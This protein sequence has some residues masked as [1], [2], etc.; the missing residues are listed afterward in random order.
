MEAIDT[1]GMPDIAGMERAWRK[2]DAERAAKMNAA[3]IVRILG[4]E[5]G[6][7]TNPSGR[8]WLGYFGPLLEGAP[9]AGADPWH[10]RR[11]REGW[12]KMMGHTERGAYAS[13]LRE[14]A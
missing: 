5:F 1:S 13:L 2:A 11:F 9:P 6:I 7:G 4:A 8:P 14:G 10:Y 12:R 3:G